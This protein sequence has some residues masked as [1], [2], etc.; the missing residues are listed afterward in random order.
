M[1]MQNETIVPALKRISLLTTAI[2]TALYFALFVFVAGFDAKQGTSF[3]ES[4]IIL[5]V[6]CVISVS[7][8]IFR[9]R[10]LHI[11][12]RTAINYTTLLLSFFIVFVSI[13]KISN[14]TPAAIL[15]TTLLFS[16]VYAI[17]FAVCIIILRNFGNN[18]KTKKNYVHLKNDKHTKNDTKEYKYTNRFS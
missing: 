10:S 3:K 2:F 15:V 11:V 14:V 16:F 1:S 12:A 18:K 13:G 5:L 7:R 6:S 17:V 4:L 9:I 8:E